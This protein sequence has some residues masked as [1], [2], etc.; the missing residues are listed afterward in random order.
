MQLFTPEKRDTL[1]FHIMT[2]EI[3][4]HSFLLA[5]FRPSKQVGTLPEHS[6]V[7]L[8]AKH[9]IFGSGLKPSMCVDAFITATIQLV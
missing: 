5:E 9:A 3:Y 7:S 4:P 6:A 2:K 1:A 8:Q